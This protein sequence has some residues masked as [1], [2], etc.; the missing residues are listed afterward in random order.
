M[1]LIGELGIDVAV[2]PIGDQFT[3][4]LAD[5]ILRDEIDRAKDRR[6]VALRHLAAD[7]SGR[8]RRACGG[9]Q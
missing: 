1:K 9:R 6:A 4:G 2:L 8:R 3:M 7:P 5:S